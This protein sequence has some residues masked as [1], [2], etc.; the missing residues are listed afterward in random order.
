M[1]SPVYWAGLVLMGDAG[2]VILEPHNKYVKWL[3]AAGVLAV[4][5]AIVFVARRKQN[6]A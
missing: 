2:T 5:G 1:K 3:W 6:A 4:L